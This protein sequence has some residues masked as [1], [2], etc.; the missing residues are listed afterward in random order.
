MVASS[1]WHQGII[2]KLLILCYFV[3]ADA[4]CFGPKV[5]EYNVRFGDPEDRL[6]AAEAKITSLQEAVAKLES[7]E[8]TEHQISKLFPVIF[9]ALLLLVSQQNRRFCLP[10]SKILV[11]F[12]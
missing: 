7:K 10:F 12:S 2:G 4:L 1:D 11:S 8:H 9:S 3:I 6:N 5:L